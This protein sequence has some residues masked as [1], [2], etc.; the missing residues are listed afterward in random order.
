MLLSVKNGNLKWV[1]I[2]IYINTKNFNTNKHVLISR[3]RIISLKYI[4][5]NKNNISIDNNYDNIQLTFTLVKSIVLIIC[6]IL[7][8]FWQF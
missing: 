2:S 7:N 5:N 8:R 6:F 4:A 1:K 3:Q